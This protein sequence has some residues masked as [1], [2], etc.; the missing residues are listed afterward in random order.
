MITR[1]DFL[2]RKDIH[3]NTTIASAHFNESTGRWTLTTTSGQ[4]IDAQY[5]ISCCGMLS[6]P[7]ENVFPGQDSFKGRIFHTARWPKEPIDFSGKRVGIVGIGATG[8]MGE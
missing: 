5:F 4:V 6:A 7:L 2:L 3:F 8:G 1:D